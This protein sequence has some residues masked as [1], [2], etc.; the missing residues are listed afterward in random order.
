[1][2]CEIGTP[3]ISCPNFILIGVSLSGSVTPCGVAV[4]PSKRGWKSPFVRLA[5]W[6]ALETPAVR[7]R[8]KVAGFIM[9]IFVVAVSPKTL[10]C[11][12]TVSD[13]VTPF[14]V[15]PPVTPLSRPVLQVQMSVKVSEG[16]GRWYEN[17]ER[18]SRRTLG[19]RLH[20]SGSCNWDSRRSVVPRGGWHIRRHR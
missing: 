13:S 17:K 12:R 19:N 20:P 2:N 7:S 9:K 10:P 3:G 5:R 16:L 1:V 8:S 11:T 6:S 15:T 18:L 14:S 4:E